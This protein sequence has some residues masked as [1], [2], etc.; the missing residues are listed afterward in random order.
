MK[1]AAETNRLGEESEL[2]RNRREGRTAPVLGELLFR[3][4]GM[5]KRRSIRSWIRN[6]VPRFEGGEI[7]SVTLRRIFAV[8]HGVQ[9]GMYSGQGCFTTGNFRKNTKI[10]RFTSIFSTARGFG[11]NH[12]MNT[13]STHAFFFNP[14]MGY[15]KEYLPP[16]TQLTIGSDVWIGHNAI[17][18]PSVTEVGHGA[19]IGAGAVVHQNVPPYGLVVGNPGRVVRYRFEKDVRETLLESQWWERSM[20]E[21]LPEFE[22]FQKPLEGEEIR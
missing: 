19:I 5:T 18:C 1:Q 6:L 8:Y 15:G 4:Y 20:E 2:E 10:G 17:I 3:V 9:I 12:P 22:S 14:S 7:Y 13:K 21:L 16:E 11:A